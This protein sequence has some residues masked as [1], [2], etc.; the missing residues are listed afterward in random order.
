[1]DPSTQAIGQPGELVEMDFMFGSDDE[2]LAE[3]WGGGSPN[4]PACFDP[5]HHAVAVYD[6]L[7]AR[8]YT[9]AGRH[10]YWIGGELE[11]VHV[12]RRGVFLNSLKQWDDAFGFP[13]RPERQEELA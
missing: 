3:V 4:D 12:T 9:F 8:P 5:E 6:R 10:G 1:M 13:L 7:R 2:E 11:R